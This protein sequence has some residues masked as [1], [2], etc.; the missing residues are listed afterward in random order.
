MFRTSMFF[1]CLVVLSGA[2]GYVCHLVFPT[3]WDI[4]VGFAGGYLIGAIGAKLYL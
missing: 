4:I 3:P 1:L 2:F